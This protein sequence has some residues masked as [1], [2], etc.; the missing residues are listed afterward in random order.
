MTVSGAA[1][2][3]VP[4]YQAQQSSFEVLG[5]APA[6]TAIDAE[7]VAAAVVRAKGKSAYNEPFGLDSFDSGTSSG[8]GLF[9]DLGLL[10]FVAYSALFLTIFINLRRRKSAEA[11]AAAS[12]FA[13]LLVL[14]FIHD[15]WE[16]P[17][18]TLLLGTL[19]AVSLTE[20]RP[21]TAPQPSSPGRVAPHAA[22]PEHGRAW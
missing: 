19:A 3:T 10:G 22:A 9:G 18:L 13:M 2:G 21:E 7:Q 11:L 6:Q 12:G 17:A 14:G 1:Y 16:T 15:W 20:P 8:V 4:A 5:L